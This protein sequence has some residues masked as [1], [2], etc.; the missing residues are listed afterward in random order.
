MRVLSVV[1]ARSELVKCAPVSRVLRARHREVLIHTGHRFDYGTDARFFSDLGLALPDRDLGLGDGTAAELTADMLSLLGSAISEA[2]PD[3]VLVYGSSH[4]TMAGALAGAKLGVPVGHVEAGLRSYRRSTHEE[5][6]RI[7][8]D[9][10]SRLHFCPTKH[11]V[12]ALAR[13]GI[14]AHVYNTGDTLLDSVLLNFERAR[15]EVGLEGL[16]QEVGCDLADTEYAFATIHQHEN[17]DDPARLGALIEAFSRLPMTVVLPLHPRTQETL[18]GRPEV[19]SRI[20][21]NVLIVDPL[22]PLSTLLAV[23]R[24]EVVLTDSGGLQREA[25]FLGVP[26]VTLRDDTEFVDTLVLSANTIVGAD[27]ERLVEAVAAARRLGRRPG[28]E[29]PAA[30]PSPATTADGAFGDGRAAHAIVRILEEHLAG[31]H[32]GPKR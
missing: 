25:F 19:V 21:E 10:V 14:E 4:A 28:A 18:Q 23:S 11:A 31:L 5:I 13:E 1:G 3:F 32:A 2:G 24:S 15:R 30:T 12:E 20:G 8:T 27:V 9:H 6:N 16:E 29:D 17:T 26:C 7:V 22:R